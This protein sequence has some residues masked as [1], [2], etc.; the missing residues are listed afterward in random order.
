MGITIRTTISG[1][2]S[3]RVPAIGTKQTD[4]APDVIVE[5]EDDAAYSTGAVV[6]IVKAVGDSAGRA[7][8][9]ARVGDR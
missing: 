6:D 1:L 8:A 7:Y 5:V 9:M 4:W 3:E 2:A